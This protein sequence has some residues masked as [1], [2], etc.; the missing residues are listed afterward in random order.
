MT[1]PHTSMT[2]RQLLTRLQYSMV[3]LVLMSVSPFRVLAQDDHLHTMTPQNQEAQTDQQ[4]KQ[5]ALLNA[6]RPVNGARGRG[7]TWICSRQAD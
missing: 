5:S 3:A 2:F 6:A 4:M 1:T 7:A